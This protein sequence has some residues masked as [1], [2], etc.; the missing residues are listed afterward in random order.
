MGFKNIKDHF[1][2]DDHTVAI[3][4]KGI[5]IGA[6]YIKHLVDIN[7]TTGE[8]V[9]NPTFRG[10]LKDKYPLLAAATPEEILRLINSSDMFEV[11]LPAYTFNG[12]EIIEKQCEA[13]GYPNVTH[14]G[15]QMYNN[16]FFEDK[17]QAIEKA[18]C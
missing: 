12:S 13:F 6:G 5:S 2:I 11:S 3:T 9:E 18:I 7:V 1:N 8:V 10:F 14:D 15:E 16:T 4:E 17:E